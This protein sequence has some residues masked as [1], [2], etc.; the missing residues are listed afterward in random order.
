MT[1]SFFLYLSYSS[2]RFH[3]GFL[4]FLSCLIAVAACWIGLGFVRRWLWWYIAFLGVCTV[5]M[6]VWFDRSC[7]LRLWCWS[8]SFMGICWT[9]QHT[10]YIHFSQALQ[11]TRSTGPGNDLPTV[12][13]RSGRVGHCTFHS[14]ALRCRHGYTML[15]HRWAFVYRLNIKI[16]FNI[17]LI[18]S[19]PSRQPYLVVSLAHTNHT[20]YTEVY[21][22]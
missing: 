2:F 8:L 12:Q 14:F 15:Y 13:Y 22:L 10:T 11:A 1:F 3:G 7:P 16:E 20:T 9:T 18:T 6:N 17:E 21:L 5:M 19:Q 4:F